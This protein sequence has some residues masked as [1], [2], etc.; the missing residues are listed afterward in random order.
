MA[1][2]FGLGSGQTTASFREKLVRLLLHQKWNLLLL[3]LSVA[4][5]ASVKRIEV[6]SV[7]FMLTV[8]I[9]LLINLGKRQ[10][11]TLS[12][13]SIYNKDFK[14]LQGDLRAE[15]FEAQIRGGP[16]PAA[17]RDEASVHRDHGGSQWAQARVADMQNEQQEEDEALQE[18]L[19]RSQT[20]R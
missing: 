15:H 17:Y 11:G 9:A 2:D 8:C 6:R 20:E 3:L 1:S 14:S 12:A 7:I 10:A 18:A 5:M 19:R 4:S 16:V 13:Y